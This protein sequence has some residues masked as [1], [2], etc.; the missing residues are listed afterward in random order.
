[1]MRP[2]PPF[3]IVRVAHAELLVTDLARSR[4]FY[5]GQ[6]GFVVTEALPD[7][8]FLR[9][10][11]DRHHH[12]LALRK[13]DRAALAHL[14]FLV[15][16]DEDLEHAARHGAEHG[17]EVRWVDD[18][19]GQGR[20]VRVMDELGFPVEYFSRMDRA[21]RL[22]Q[23]YDLQRGAR[24]RRIDHFNLHVPDVQAAFD[25]YSDLGFRCSEYIQGD[26]PDRT[27]YAAW[28]F[29]KPTTHDVALTGG[30]GPRLHH[31]AFW[32][33][34]LTAIVQLCDAMGGANRY[35]SIERGPG[36]HGVSNAFYLYLRDPDGHR[37][38]LF[39]DDYWTGDPDLEPIRWSVHEERRRSFWGHSVP[40]R[41]YLESSAVVDLDGNP[42]PLVQPATEEMKAAVL[43]R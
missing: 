13:G 21:D 35:G 31:I 37:I 11:E 18:E 17:R 5:E 2:A 7:A 8:L 23:R 27:L 41:W 6:L 40:E 43:P 25:H 29:R 38:E 39:T 36:R 22:L 30:A 28:L 9:G 19:P 15:A 34:D 3:D 33:G 26:E 14:A 24:P 4:E 10:Y 16:S 32:V 20:A 12:C 42:V 1:M